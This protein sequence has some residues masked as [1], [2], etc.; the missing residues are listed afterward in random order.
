MRSS[1]AW[2]A[3]L[4]TLI[5]ILTVL[6]PP[7]ASEPQ[8][9]TVC[10]VPAPAP[11]KGAVFASPDLLVV[12]AYNSA[13][14][15]GVYYVNLSTCSVSSG[16]VLEGEYV[17]SEAGG[18]IALVVTAAPGGGARG[19]LVRLYAVLPNKTVVKLGEVSARYPGASSSLFGLTSDA[20]LALIVADN[21]AFLVDVGR[22]KILWHLESGN[23]FVEGALRNGSAYLVSLETMCY[24]CIVLKLTK[25]FK[26]V[27]REGAKL[28]TL[29]REN[30]LTIVPSTDGESILLLTKDLKILRRKIG[31]NR[32]Q[33][34]LNVKSAVRGADFCE[35]VSSYTKGARLTRPYARFLYIPLKQGGS[36]GVFVYN[37]KT[38]HYRW[39]A[40]TYMPEGRLRKLK[41]HGWDNGAFFVEASSLSTTTIAFVNVSSGQQ[42]LLAESSAVRKPRF[43]SYLPETNA[44]A[45]MVHEGHEAYLE[46]ASLES[47][48]ELYELTVVVTDDEGRSISAAIRVGTTVTGT[49]ENGTITLH[50]PPGKYTVEAWAPGYSHV[51]KEVS[52]SRDTK[53]VLTLRS[54]TSPLTVRASLSDGRPLSGR[55]RVVTINGTVLDEQVLRNGM[56]SF[57][58]PDN[59]YTIEV[60]ANGTLLLRRQVVLS[61]PT[62][63]KLVVPLVEYCFVIKSDEGEPLSSVTVALADKY[64][65][66][67]YYAKG[68]PQI[69]I[70]AVNATYTAKIFAEGFSETEVTVK[71]GEGC[72]SVSLKPLKSKVATAGGESQPPSLTYYTAALGGVAVLSALAL[73]LVRKHKG[74][75]K[76]IEG[77]VPRLGRKRA[78]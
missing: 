12:F 54:S 70:R 57:I 73:L 59:Q 60:E 5:A 17:A 15:T 38:G 46:L 35:G 29:E 34:V 14:K 69:V 25:W 47:K 40:C 11:I 50:L 36:Y 58:L 75:V 16:P 20:S 28:W 27:T 41:I 63:V 9:K 7:S 2:Q 23:A 33:S 72:L 48:T 10:R 44:V 55:I 65:I 67:R 4:L 56:A 6:P 8:F 26:I 45:L 78:G 19:R 32:E 31:E 21:V 49:G 24:S 3:L 18:D 42:L 66:V 64:G 52:L 61:G 71:G 68:G 1:R 74:R 39:V 76:G 43:L 30:V 13:F 22:R 37:L 51:I 53:L 77:S 62:E